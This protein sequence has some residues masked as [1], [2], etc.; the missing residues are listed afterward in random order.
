GFGLA[1]LVS[2]YE[3]R[4]NQTKDRLI[5]EKMLASIDLLSRLER[6]INRKQLLINAHIFANETKEMEDA[7]RQISAVDA[8]FTDA[9]HAYDAI[10]RETSERQSWDEL[11]VQLTA[12]TPDLEGVIALS[13]QN[14]D[15]EAR[16]AMRSIE[17]R[18]DTVNQS[19]EKLIDRNRT[20]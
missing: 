18:F 11:Q 7:E 20:E 10:A 17:Q 6:D 16:A 1:N 12:L 4:G 9:G 15:T 8:D 19:M 5:V 14:R 3:M 13:R 2:L